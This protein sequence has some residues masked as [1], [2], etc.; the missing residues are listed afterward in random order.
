MGILDQ[1]RNTAALDRDPFN[2]L[3]WGISGTGKTVTALYVAKMLGLNPIVFDA[4]GGGSAVYGKENG[5]LG[6]TFEALLTDDPETVLNGL[7]ELCAT[8][9]DYQLAIVDPISNVSKVIDDLVDAEGRRVARQT[10][11]AYVPH[12]NKGWFR[13]VQRANSRLQSAIRN[14]SIC[15]PVICSAHQANEWD[16]DKVVG[17]RPDGSKDLENPFMVVIQLVKTKTGERIAYVRKDRLRRLP[18]EPIVLHD[19]TTLATALVTAYGDLFRR[20]TVERPICTEDQVEEIAGLSEGLGFSHE[21][22]VAACRRKYGVD[23]PEQLSP[24][25]AGEVIAGMRAKL[26]SMRERMAAAGHL[27]GSSGA[28][29]PASPSPT[30][31]ASPTSQTISQDPRPEAVRTASPSA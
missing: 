13:P 31:P 22:I 5:G 6:F 8:P 29:A 21:Q 25:Q 12:T 18:A 28:P 1:A 15:M 10:L 23:R 2:V 24:A 7:R 27:P 26:D 3:L 16:G 4:D 11:S 17:T 14:L 20:P 9:R 30:S 19:A